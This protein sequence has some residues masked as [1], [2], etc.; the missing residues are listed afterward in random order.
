MEVM[1]GSLRMGPGLCTPWLSLE[2][3]ALPLLLLPQVPTGLLVPTIE[4]TQVVLGTELGTTS[5][6]DPEPVGSSESQTVGCLL[7][8]AWEEVLG[9][10]TASIMVTAPTG[11]LGWVAACGGGGDGRV[12]S[13]RPGEQQGMKE[14]LREEARQCPPRH[15]LA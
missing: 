6:A 15:P 12:G 5:T 7:W 14:M 3:L 13:S 10:D 4:E 8:K 1:G 11:W 2:L 9:P